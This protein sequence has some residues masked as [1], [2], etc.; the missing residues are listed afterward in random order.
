MLRFEF[1]DGT[2]YEGED[3]HDTPIEQIRS[4]AAYTNLPIN[5]PKY[6]YTYSGIIRMTNEMVIKFPLHFLVWEQ[7]KSRI[8]VPKGI[9]QKI[10]G[11]VYVAKH[12]LLDE[13]EA[14]TILPIQLKL[15]HA[16]HTI[17]Y[18]VDCG[19]YYGKIHANPNTST[20]S[21]LDYITRKRKD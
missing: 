4:V 21:Y 8:Q 15:D 6:G 7:V 18:F 17:R 2:Y 20:R 12:Y 16:S 9:N 3:P 11:L 14:G 5:E 19:N 10:I 13:F 1:L